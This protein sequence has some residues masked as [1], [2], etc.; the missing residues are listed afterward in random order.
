M[1]DNPGSTDPNAAT[2]AA[3]LDALNRKQASRAKWS[4]IGGGLILF[5]IAIRGAVALFGS[6]EAMGCSDSET[7]STLT[8]AINEKEQQS[9]L[10]ARVASIDGIQQISHDSSLSRCSGRLAMTDQSSGT[11]TYHVDRKQVQVDSVN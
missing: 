8:S 6:H 4:K 2:T 5:A 10:T 3:A 7:V 9:N 1:N 11:I